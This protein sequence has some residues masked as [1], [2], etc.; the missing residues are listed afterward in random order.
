MTQSVKLKTQ[1]KPNFWRLCAAPMMGVTHRHYRY[2]LRLISPR[3]RLYSEMLHARAVLHGDRAQL[4]GF[5]ALEQ[6]VALQLGGCDAKS[7]ATAARIGEQHGYAEINLNIGCPSPRVQSGQFG[8]CLM[9]QPELVAEC[10]ALMKANV[11]CPVTIKT[12]IGVDHDDHYEFLER[13][14]VA[15]IDAGAD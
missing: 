7:L 6:P 5:D 4:L 15:V 14:A 3:T 11:R 13:L 9:R 12:R 1:I 10:V 8:V 2:L